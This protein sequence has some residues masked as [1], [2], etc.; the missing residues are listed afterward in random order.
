MPPEPILAPG[1]ELYRHGR[2]QI[3]V[4]LG[5]RPAAGA[6]ASVRVPD[7]V[8]WQLLGLHLTFVAS[9]AVATRVISLSLKSDAGT[10]YTAPA[11]TTVTASQTSEVF[12]HT[13]GF[14]WTTALADNPIPLPMFTPLGPG[15]TILTSTALIDSADQYAAPVLW[16]LEW[17]GPVYG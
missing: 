9:A 10:F 13:A 1:G 6:E 2:G 12:A 8:I 3:Q 17:E 4:V 14:N 15:Y 5:P 7:N 11:G 16:L